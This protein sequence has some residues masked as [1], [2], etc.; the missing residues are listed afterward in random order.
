MDDPFLP[1]YICWQRASVTFII[2]KAIKLSEKR[3]NNM[4]GQDKQITDR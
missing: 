3:I 4:K 1:F 2:R